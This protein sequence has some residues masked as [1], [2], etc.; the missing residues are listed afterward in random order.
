MLANPSI[1]SL[2][3]SKPIWSTGDHIFFP[4]LRV[5]NLIA[6]GENKLFSKN[7]V[8]FQGIMLLEAFGK[9]GQF[10]DLTKWHTSC[11]S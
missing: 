7:I 11:I 6:I 5:F 3:E 1:N 4:V 8:Y 10:Q 9:R 2:I